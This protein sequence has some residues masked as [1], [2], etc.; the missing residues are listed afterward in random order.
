MM[1][2][3][4]HEHRR[5]LWTLWGERGPEVVARGAGVPPDVYILAVGAGEA[6]DED[7]HARLTRYALAG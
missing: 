4:D 7:T 3:L 5:R 2:K 6:V 1:L